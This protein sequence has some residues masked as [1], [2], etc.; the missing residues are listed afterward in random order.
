MLQ[1]WNVDVVRYGASLHD[2]DTYYLMRAYA[3]LDDCQ[4]SQDAFYGSDEW[5]LGPSESIIAPIENYTSVVIGMDKSTVD[6]LRQ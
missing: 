4:Q 3:S 1:R 6:E 5:K 2:E